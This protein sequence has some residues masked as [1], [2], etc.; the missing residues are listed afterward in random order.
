MERLSVTQSVRDP[1][2]SKSDLKIASYVVKNAFSPIA[3]VRRTR[4]PERRAYDYVGAETVPMRYRT[5][6]HTHTGPEAD[7]TTIFIYSMIYV[8]ICG[9][10][11]K[12][13]S[14]VSMNQSC[15]FS[16]ALKSIFSDFD[17]LIEPRV[18]LN[19]KPQ[20]FKFFSNNLK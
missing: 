1:S 3:G 7:N 13:P 6:A 17:K 4:A 9:I 20:V 2:K 5:P 12:E 15:F 19:Q 10:M 8:F 16:L 11:I 14:T 18:R